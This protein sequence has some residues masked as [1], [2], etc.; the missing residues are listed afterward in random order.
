M[1]IFSGR[2]GRLAVRLVSPPLCGHTHWIAGR[3]ALCPASR[4]T[5]PACDLGYRRREA[6]W[7]VVEVAEAGQVMLWNVAQPILASM[8]AATARYERG[9]FG[10]WCVIERTHTN[11]PWRV[12]GTRESL[13]PGKD[14]QESIQCHVARIFGIKA[15]ADWEAT[16]KLP[17]LPLLLCSMIR[18]EDERVNT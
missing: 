12:I 8:L 2:K 18:T 10:H 14:W 17:A 6:T 1:K 3:S 13:I 9:E 5:C 4:Q 15:A 16:L 11:L 7:V